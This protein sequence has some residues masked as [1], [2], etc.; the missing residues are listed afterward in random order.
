MSPCHSLY[1]LFF[2]YISHKNGSAVL[3]N[4]AG[5]KGALFFFF[6][7]TFKPVS[8]SRGTRYVDVFGYGVSFSP[9]SLGPG[10]GK[11]EYEFFPW[12]P[13]LSVRIDVLL[14][15]QLESLDCSS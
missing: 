8:L 2:G 4:N 5:V 12:L 9:A 13:T 15:K 14:Y 6:F 3:E 7:S 10:R 1:C 11:I